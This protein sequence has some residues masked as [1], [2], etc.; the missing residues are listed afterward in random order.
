MKLGRINRILA[1]S[2]FVLPTARGQRS[3]PCGGASACAPSAQQSGTAKKVAGSKGE[4]TSHAPENTKASA[5]LLRAKINTSQL[6]VTVG[7][8]YGIYAEL[9]N[10][11]TS[12][13]TIYSR[14][15]ILAVQPEVTNTKVCVYRIRAFFPT[16]YPPGPAEN[17]SP[18]P[19]PVPIATPTPQQS[20]ASAPKDIVPAFDSKK[21]APIRIP[22]SEH[23]TVFW[24]VSRSNTND[25][26]CMKPSHWYDWFSFTP[27][28]YA[29]TIDGKAY[30]DGE[31]NYHTYTES[32][33]LRVSIA[34]FWAVLA[35]AIGGLLA[36]IVTAL[37]PGK[38]VDKLKAAQDRDKKSARSTIIRGILSAPLL[39]ASVTI[40]FSRLAE[41]QFP[42]KISINDVWGALTVGFLSFFV[43][44]KIIEK[45]VGTVKG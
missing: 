31:K 15:T 24:D 21:G 36:Y 38:D 10:T 23:Y 43:G 44:N 2:L 29:F 13:V 8:S 33:N 18:T 14:E 19:T 9:E 12:A 6:E 16:E 1:V 39:A 37:Q 26:S 40:V 28:E 11:A 35:A 42:I 20:S 41:T 34:Q 5:G 22:P 45:L 3:K 27:G 30:L 4:M 17:S 25:P 32:T 7:G